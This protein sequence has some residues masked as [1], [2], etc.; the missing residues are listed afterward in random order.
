MKNITITRTTNEKAVRMIY[1]LV[2]HC[3]DIPESR[4]LDTL[5]T[6]KKIVSSVINEEN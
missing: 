2:Y 4:L 6:I 1:D 5:I 3:E